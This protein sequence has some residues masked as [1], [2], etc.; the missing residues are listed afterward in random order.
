M[1]DNKKRPLFDKKHGQ[2]RDPDGPIWL[3]G[4]HAV[5]AALNNKARHQ[6]TLLATK[7]AL[8]WLAEQG[9][10]IPIE[11][12]KPDAIDREL[13]EG[14]VHQGLAMK[15]NPLPAP[16]LEEVLGSEG[17]GPFLVLDQV[18]DPQNIGALMR[19]AAAFGAAAVIGQDR[20]TPPLAGALAKAAAGAV[21]LLPF[22]RV[23]NIA[24]TL[25]ELRANDVLV[26][27]LAGDGS[28]PLPDFQTQHRVAIVLGAEGTG[29]RPKVR[30]GCDQM[31][32]IPIADE[33]E[34]LNV[35]TAAAVALYATTAGRPA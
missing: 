5:L 2:S 3:Y 14:A 24:R 35:A 8:D 6:H 22:I 16:S 17:T 34:S 1:R 25:S 19:V 10:E 26:I 28:V 7:N 9:R 23:V 30:E 27:G 18:T 31:V 13:P 12:V 4:R 21:E 15:V 11:P 33:V 32:T 20:R 29:L